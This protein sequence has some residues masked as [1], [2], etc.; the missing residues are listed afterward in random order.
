MTFFILKYFRGVF[1]QGRQI[2]STNIKHNRKYTQL[3]TPF[4]TLFK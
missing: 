2:L 3:S 4:S 1:F